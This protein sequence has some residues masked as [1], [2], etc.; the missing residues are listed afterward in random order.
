MIDIYY[1]YNPHALEGRKQSLQESEKQ[2]IGFRLSD[3]HELVSFIVLSL[4]ETPEET[5]SLTP[6]CLCAQCG[7]RFAFTSHTE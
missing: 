6:T 4:E 3:A 7:V 5:L 1:M 2:E